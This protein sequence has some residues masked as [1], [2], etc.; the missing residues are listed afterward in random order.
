MNAHRLLNRIIQGSLGILSVL[1]VAGCIRHGA[2]Q[3]ASSGQVYTVGSVPE[4][5]ETLI[6]L[7]PGDELILKDGVYADMGEVNLS[8]SGDPDRP[9][10]IRPKTPHQVRFTGELR[11]RITGSH[12]QIHG[13]IFD[14]C[15]KAPSQDRWGSL[16]EATNSTRGLQISGCRFLSCESERVESRATKGPL[17]NLHGDRHRVNHNVFE[18]PMGVMLGIRGDDAQMQKRI[19]GYVRIDHNLFRDASRWR[20]ESQQGEAIFMGTGFSH[21]RT[22]PLGAVVE[23]NVFD[24]AIG[25]KHG[26]IITVKAS[27]VTFRNNIFAH[28]P[29]AWFEGGAHLSLRHTDNVTVENN[30]FVNLGCGIWVTGKG[31]TI[32]NNL[33]DQIDFA[34]LYFPSGNLREVEDDRAVIMV[35]GARLEM[36]TPG[37]YSRISREYG[38]VFW[39]AE[40]C[41]IEHNTFTNLSKFAFYMRDNRKAERG[42]IPPSDNR[43]E[44]NIFAAG[45]NRAQG[46]FMFIDQPEQNSMTNNLYLLPEPFPEDPFGEHAVV[47]RPEE[48]PDWKVHGHSIPDARPQTGLQESLELPPLPPMPGSLREQPLRAEFQAISTTVNTGDYLMLDASF[49]AG[50]IIDYQWDFGDGS[51]ISGGENA[52]PHRWTREGIYMVTLRV[53]D[54]EQQQATYQKRIQVTGPVSPLRSPASF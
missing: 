53:R 37:I 46:P 9:I 22:R 32:R 49:S 50:S 47:V 19:P 2:S 1:L 25:D 11:W 7:E 45:K 6:R 52:V 28:G 51:R 4:F 15:R 5:R 43:V 44:A 8:R 14:R 35:D 24:R 54:A 31:H 48:V 42:F 39:A 17:V 23:Y 41:V 13:L 33:F 29:G 36:S 21:Y 16:I 34:G 38:A 30:L 40:Q 26:E 3:P 12:L 18:D 20:E 27:D 10:I